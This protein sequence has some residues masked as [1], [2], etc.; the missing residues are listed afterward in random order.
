[1]AAFTFFNA[2]PRTLLYDNLL[3]RATHN[4]FYVAPAVMWSDYVM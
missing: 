4:R 2:V 1:V 3:C